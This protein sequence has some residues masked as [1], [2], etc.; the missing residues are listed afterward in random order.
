MAQF[1][2]E[3]TGNGAGVGV[4]GMLAAKLDTW[5]WRKVLLGWTE[6]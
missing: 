3:S 2:A 5:A 4:G 6:R 1:N